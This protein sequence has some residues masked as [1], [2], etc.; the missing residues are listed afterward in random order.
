MNVENGKVG[1]LTILFMIMLVIVLF[2]IG[3]VL[4]NY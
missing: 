3:I 4:L 2:L 1:I